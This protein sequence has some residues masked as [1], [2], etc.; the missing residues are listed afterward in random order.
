MKEIVCFQS[1]SPLHEGEQG[2]R[3]A[4]F[5]LNNSYK[6]IRMTRSLCYFS[7]DARTK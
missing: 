1:A 5:F 4:Q 7:Y 3:A 2:R 6:N